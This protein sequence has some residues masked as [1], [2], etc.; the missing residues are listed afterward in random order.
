MARKLHP[1]RT[2][3]LPEEAPVTAGQAAQA[4]AALDAALVRQLGALPLLLPLVETLGLRE[5]VNRHCHPDGL[6]P[7]D[8]DVGLVVLVLVLN[9]LQAPQPL[10]HV[11]E[12]IRDSALVDLLALQPEQ[13][14]DDRLAR[15]LDGVLPHLDAIWE[16][17]IR[18]LVT[19]FPVD[20]SA[21]CYDITSISFCGDYEEADLV[22]YGY[23]RDHRP[24]RKQIE[25]AA[26]VTAAGGIPIDYRPLAGNVADSTT[27]VENLHRLQALLALLPPR[28][29][30]APNLVISDRAMLTIEAL[31]AFAQSK[32]YYLGPLDPG[33]GKGAVRDLLTS[34]SGEELASHP[35][36]YRPQ[37][38]AKDPHWVAYCGVTGTLELAVD[39]PEHPVLTVRTLV[40]WS[41]GKARLDAKQRET[42]LQRLEQDLTKLA[43]KVGRRPYTTVAT[44]QKRLRTLC[45]RHPARH[46]LTTTITGGPKTDQPLQLTWTRNDT[47]L[48][49]AAE[50]D[51]RYVLGTNAPDLDA[52]AMLAQSKRRDVPEKRFA[53]VK[54]PLAVRPVYVHKE[55][56]ILGLVFCTMLALLLFALLELLARQAGLTLS[57]QQL[58]SACAT[59]TL[60][61][62]R[63]RDG[64]TLRQVAGVSP[65]IAA[66]LAAVH[67]PQPEAYVQQRR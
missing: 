43:G 55:E 57:G 29:A 54:G 60:V 28:P 51:G 6:I 34:V 52:A 26:T 13:F 41:P 11:E 27:P 35:L 21:L 24:D 49:E 31:Q 2:W 66:F 62:L 25:L 44:V 33:V 45:K 7:E 37:R 53:L 22:R 5:I 9:R 30:A 63:W 19:T 17:V 46:F 36:P 8:V 67:W 47:A 48:A 58:F 42:Y 1:I 39:N 10:V 20:L 14:N 32:L 38:S 50:L 3:R 15:A 4:E 16:E 59:I 23:S 64:T 56:R 40:V 18:R 12:W 65:P 61:V